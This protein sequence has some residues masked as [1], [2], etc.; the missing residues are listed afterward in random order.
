MKKIKCVTIRMLFL[1]AVLV[2][3]C[4][5]FSHGPVP[6][7]TA[8]PTQKSTPERSL[9]PSPSPAQP[10]ELSP[11][12]VSGPANT[13]EITPSLTPGDTPSCT[14]V[15]GVTD[16]S[17]PV[18]DVSPA[19]TS[20][21]TPTPFPTG[22]MFDVCIIEIMYNPNSPD[23]EWEWIEV[24][25]N[26]ITEIDLSGWII[27]DCNGTP[28][29]SS[30]ILSGT[31]SPG[32]TAILFNS[33]ALTEDEFQAAWYRESNL[34]PVTSW[35]AMGLNN[36]GD[37]LSLWDTFSSYQGDHLLHTNAFHTV[38][39]SDDAPWPADN[40]SGSIYLKDLAADYT[41]GANWALSA[42]GTVTP[43]GTCY[44]STAGGTNTGADIGSP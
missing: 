17:T 2:T 19:P 5:E 1:F 11:T 27:D 35:G 24:F 14:P 21:V 6:A 33:D 36:T 26:T 8:Q 41:N 18:P 12:P 34:I 22:L 28:H 9:E 30:N 13:P 32:G 40:G 23:S 37:K 42:I 39:Y 31:L 3:G 29:T 43:A 7:I 4:Q 44:Q 38:E 15:P 20:A 10:G 25:N 16:E